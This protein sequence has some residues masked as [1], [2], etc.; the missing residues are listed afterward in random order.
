MG[1]KGQAMDKTPWDSL[2]DQ[3]AELMQSAYDHADKPISP[4]KAH[5][6]GQ[7]LDELEKKV[8][9]FKALIDKFSEESGVN[10]YAFNA[11][12]AD[13]EHP[14]HPVLTRGEELKVEA[15]KGAED[16]LK[17]SKEV[18]A[19]GKRLTAAKKEKKS[20]TPQTRKGKFKSMGGY[21][22]WKPL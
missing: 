11:M 2:F 3:I 7:K 15:K 12:L 8:K 9:E 14:V 18:K 13:E 22:N 16:V 4:Q 10:A 20:S 1:K 6:A 19:S 21:K 5:Q 17:A